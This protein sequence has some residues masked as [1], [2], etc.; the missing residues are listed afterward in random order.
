M[1]LFRDSA[2]RLHATSWR[3]VGLLSALAITIPTSSPIHAQG[4]LAVS[5]VNMIPH[6]LSGESRTDSEPNLAV[7]PSNTQQ[8]AASA[9]TPDPMGGPNAPIYLSTDGGQTWVLNSIVPG[10]NPTTAQTT[11]RSGSD[12][13]SNVLYAATLRGDESATG[14]AEE[15]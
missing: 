1:K 3:Y 10:G 7:N 11:S 6:S 14:G 4:T 15:S 5:V 12:P 13:A 2:S 9:F 8:I